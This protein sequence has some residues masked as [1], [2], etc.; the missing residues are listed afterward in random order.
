MSRYS[1][2][3]S[4]FLTGVAHLSR[5]AVAFLLI[6]VIAYYLGPDGLGALGHFMSLATMLYMVAGGG[7]TN[8]VI[9]YS[10]EYNQSPRR[11]AR[12]VS[13]SASYSLVC[14]LAVGVIGIVFSKPV[15][16]FVFND[17]GKWWLVVLL[18]LAQFC[19][20]Y[21][22]IVVGV[23]N[24]LLATHVYSRIQIIGS[25]LAMSLVAWLVP[26][27]GFEGAAL[28]TIAIYLA[29][30]LPAI[31]FHL[32]FRLRRHVR[33][34]KLSTSEVRGFAKFSGM[35][36]VS[37]ASFPVVEITVRQFLI[38]GS[39][40][41][42]AGLWQGLMKLSSAYLGFFTI[43][44]SYYFMPL[45]SRENNKGVI[46][47]L[48]LKMLSAVTVLF[49]F[50]A[51]CLYVGRDFFIGHLLSA[52]F[53]KAAD[54]LG[55]QLVGD[56]FRVAAYVIGFVA[57][58]KAS[59]KLYVGAEVLQNGLFVLFVYGFGAQSSAVLTVVQ[60]YALTYVIYF[61]VA[62]ACFVLYVSRKCS[63]RGTNAVS[64]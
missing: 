24:G 34:V 56:G 33:L 18:S 11:L 51:S 10:S 27:L 64:C 16:G 17:S 25:L 30:V 47:G 5:I 21:V 40:Y 2:I 32:R 1:A 57:V 59:V 6:K 28:A 8:A 49:V 58:A 54:Y 37:A 9:K 41:E 50:G 55:Y 38:N 63:G 31:Y 42:Q 48:T 13:A 4:A 35:M 23:G 36:I 45:I 52:E 43:F 26:V 44:L 39:G 20:A 62:V 22:N 29:P 12:V 3:K 61:L 19:Y 15:A 60:A 53:G 7:I 14:C 46:R